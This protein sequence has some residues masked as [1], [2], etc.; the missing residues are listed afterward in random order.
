MRREAR[1]SYPPGVTMSGSVAD[2]KI[3]VTTFG[4]DAGK[5]G[6]GTYLQRILE[7]WDSGEDSSSIEIL[8]HPAEEEAWG[9]NRF[10]KRWVNDRFRA[11]LPNILWHQTRL[12]AACRKNRYDV[13]FLPAGNR[14]LPWSLPCASV[15]TVHDLSV[16]HVPGKY[17]RAREL[18]ITQVLPRLMNR[19][20]RIITVSE[21]S[22]RDIVEH[23]EVPEA[24]VVVIP[25][26]VDHY[27]FRPKNRDQAKRRA[28]ALLGTEDPYILFVSR[29]EH[30]GKNHVRLID[31]FSRF[32]ATGVH[33]H[34]LVLVGKDWSRAD[35]VHRAAVAS[36][37]ASDIL[38][39]GFVELEDLPDLYAAS[40]MTA[41][42]SLYEGFGIPVLEAMACGAP[43]AC[44]DT[45][46]LPEV[47]GDAA[48]LF[49]PRDP[50]SIA[51]SLLRLTSDQD[52]RARLITEG[53]SRC[54]R[55]SWEATASRTLEVLREAHAQWQAE[56]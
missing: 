54:R 37:F 44:S 45:S 36:P 11:P 16:L 52:L 41:F 49:D 33:P 7:V 48:L 6:I 13:L 21:S 56:Q 1:Y 15:G 46:S 24:K 34:K 17:D 25:N 4:G 18:Y 39:P 30:P 35:E 5:S 23:S 51:E 31:A 43:V 53:H 2:P 26:G 38:F 40:Q 14:R 8:A 42:P 12:G 27:R 29:I 10:E 55:F 20:T 32:R 22:K 50:A 19:L 3:G 9:R 28:A 47:A